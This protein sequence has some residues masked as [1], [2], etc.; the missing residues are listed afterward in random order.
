MHALPS[1]AGAVSRST[2][3]KHDGETT[4]YCAFVAPEYEYDGNRYK[5]DTHRCS[6]KDGW[7]QYDTEQDAWYF[8]VWYHRERR[9]VVTYAEGDET[10]VVCQ[11][12]ESFRAE[13]AEMA[14]FY[15]EPPPAF[16]GIDV[17]TGTVT[18]FYDEDAR[19][20]V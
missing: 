15:G 2:T 19:P 12:E 17:D 9:L 11:T 1:R 6:S 10:I 20:T 4:V 16:V 7:H 5:Y 14:E 18:E 13:L 8:G 3:A